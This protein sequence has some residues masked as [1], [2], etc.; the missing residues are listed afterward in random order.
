MKFNNQS[1]NKVSIIKFFDLVGFN[2]KTQKKISDFIS[3]KKDNFSSCDEFLNKEL[4]SIVT[5]H[6]HNKDL[7]LK[8]IVKKEILPYPYVFYLPTIAD[9][10]FEVDPTSDKLFYFFSENTLKNIDMIFLPDLKRNTD[11][12]HK[13]A[14]KIFQVIR[15]F[16]SDYLKDKGVK[17]SKRYSSE[18]TELIY[19][20]YKKVNKVEEAALKQEKWKNEFN[21]QLINVFEKPEIL[22]NM[23]YEKTFYDE[24]ED[25]IFHFL[26]Y[27]VFNTSSIKNDKSVDYR[28]VI[29]YLKKSKIQNKRNILNQSLHGFYEFKEINQDIKKN[30][31]VLLTYLKASEKKYFKDINFSEVHYLIKETS[32]EVDIYY[33]FKKFMKS[34]IAFPAGSKPAFIKKDFLKSII[35]PLWRQ[36]LSDGRLP[37]PEVEAFGQILKRFGIELNIEDAEY[38]KEGKN[39]K[40]DEMI[41]E[42]FEEIKDSTIEEKYLL[43]FLLFEISISD[44]HFSKESEGNFIVDYCKAVFPLKDPE[45][46][47]DPEEVSKKIFAYLM[48]IDCIFNYPRGFKT[49]K[50]IIKKI[51]EVMFLKKDLKDKINYFYLTIGYVF[52]FKIN[53]DVKEID[54]EIVDFCFL[55][56]IPENYQLDY[57]VKNKAA[58]EKSP[59]ESGPTFY[60]DNL[61]T[62]SYEFK[63]KV[64]NLPLRKYEQ[65]I[66][67]DKFRT[68]KNYEIFSY[69]MDHTKN[70]VQLPSIIHYLENFL[71]SIIIF[72]KDKEDC[73][74]SAFA[75]VY[76]ELHF[77]N[78][79]LQE[80]LLTLDLIVEI[81][82]MKNSNIIKHKEWESYIEGISN[83]LGLNQKDLEKILLK[84][85]ILLGFTL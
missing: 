16:H 70:I 66:K 76:S 21:N 85:N 9:N 38:I 20:E 75:G 26:S 19:E 6:G 29:S 80:R 51:F 30:A 3:N 14:T 40:N 63:K 33:P 79:E 65:N 24:I 84:Y 81:I 62:F 47:Q 36:C 13:N 64:G 23:N 45:K 74:L 25:Y 41:E 43:L 32:F 10:L 2:S 73:D 35:K 22:E 83:V 68:K 44:G 59:G 7:V 55:Y 5:V 15:S 17:K 48:L 27:L 11:D 77:Q 58:Y 53:R 46:G 4:K 8:E 39:L 52:F 69:C 50:E 57:Q 28:P 37:P 42:L 67:V 54:R 49:G 71:I 60:L 72:S 12:F 18:A 78:L 31:V 82:S 61:S 1:L 56:L 34:N